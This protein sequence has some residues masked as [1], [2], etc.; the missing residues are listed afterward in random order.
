MTNTYVLS[1]VN[2]VSLQH[3]LQEV[4]EKNRDNPSVIYSLIPG[5]Y[6]WERPKETFATQ[7]IKTLAT[8]IVFME[9]MKAKTDFLSNISHSNITGSFIGQIYK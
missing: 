5:D 7:F 8:R 4:F 2:S 1:S 9:E 6:L 3:L